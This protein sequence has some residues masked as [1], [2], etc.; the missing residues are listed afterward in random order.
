MLFTV[1]QA[2][3]GGIPTPLL[4][5]LGLIP[6]WREVLR[7]APRLSLFQRGYGSTTGYKRVP[8]MQPGSGWGIPSAAA[9]GYHSSEDTSWVFLLFSAITRVSVSLGC[10]LPIIWRSSRAQPPPCMRSQQAVCR[11]RAPN[12]LRQGTKAHRMATGPDLLLLHPRGCA[13]SHPSPPRIYLQIKPR[14][15]PPPPINS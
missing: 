6:S 5:V 9:G 13:G 7:R 11:G 3:T 2:S 10:Y 15:E 8:R 4:Q 12:P 1:S 14:K